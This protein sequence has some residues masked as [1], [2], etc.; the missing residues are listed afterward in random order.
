MAAGALPGLEGGGGGIFRLSLDYVRRRAET[1][2]V[3]GR[4]GGDGSGQRRA[5][6]G[7]RCVVGGDA[8]GEA[9]AVLLRAGFEFA[10]G[11]L[12]PSR[13]RRRLQSRS[14][15]QWSEGSCVFWSFVC[16]AWRRLV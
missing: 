4:E 16:A 12:L 9:A 3:A 15:G 11:W 7:R 14:A 2:G 8:F 13:G 1:S 5:V 6:N 10:G